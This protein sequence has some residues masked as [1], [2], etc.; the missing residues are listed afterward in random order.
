MSTIN[1]S[2][3]GHLPTEVLSVAANQRLVDLGFL[4]DRQHL[5]SHEINNRHTAEMAFAVASEGLPLSAAD[6]MFVLEWLATKYPVIDPYEF[7]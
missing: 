1:R 2:R 4:Q 7:P 3:K 6:K 5:Y